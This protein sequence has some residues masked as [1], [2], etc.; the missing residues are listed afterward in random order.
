VK[1]PQG[2]FSLWVLDGLTTTVPANLLEHD[3]EKCAR[4]SDDIILY[5][6]DVDQDSDFRPIEPKIILI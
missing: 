3:A 5:F 6:F 4:C 1:L 2:W